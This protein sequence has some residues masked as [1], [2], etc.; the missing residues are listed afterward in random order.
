MGLARMA[1]ARYNRKIRKSKGGKAVGLFESKKKALVLFASPKGHGHARMLLE[2]FL[3]GFKEEKGWEIEEMDLYSM[4][5][6]PCVACGACA[7]KEACQFDDLDKFDKAL[8]KSDLLVVASPV[9]NAS[10]PAP[11][12]ALLDRTQRYF[13]ARFSLNKRPPIKKH[14]EAVLLLTMGSQEDFGVEVTTYQLKRSFSVMNTE[15]TGCVVWDSTDR[16]REN[17][18]PAQKK[19][20]T[21][22]LEIL[23]R[24]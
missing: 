3:E 10:F 11:M 16:G 21:L 24:M 12:K 20:R 6:K 17:Q 19:A 8:R 1:L 2:S 15:L 18:V 9:Y 22:G 7:Q 5:P 23:S 14:R 4:E 13:E